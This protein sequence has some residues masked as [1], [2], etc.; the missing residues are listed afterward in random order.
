MVSHERVGAQTKRRS[1]A[2][3]C[4]TVTWLMAEGCGRAPGSS[5]TLLRVENGSSSSSISRQMARSG[6]GNSATSQRKR[7][8]PA[9]RRNYRARGA[10]SYARLA[11][12]AA[13][14]HRCCF[15]GAGLAAAASLGGRPAVWL[16]PALSISVA[17]AAAAEAAG[18]ASSSGEPAR[19]LLGAAKMRDGSRR[20]GLGRE[21]ASTAATTNAVFDR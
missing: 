12:F 19:V 1:V 11:C 3:C 21:A 18:G 2:S 5:A 17:A 4:E 6:R 13:V 14:A 20:G 15:R 9:T 16:Y 10:A 7:S 8:G